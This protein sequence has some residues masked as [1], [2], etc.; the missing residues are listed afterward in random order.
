M[1]WMQS[2]AQARND[3]DLV[4]WLKQLEPKYNEVEGEIR[5]VNDKLTRIKDTIT[6]RGKLCEK[7]MEH[8]DAA[9]AAAEPAREAPRPPKERSSAGREL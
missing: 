9:A 4:Q 2:D 3:N 1:Q 8:D 5:D 6:L 7:V